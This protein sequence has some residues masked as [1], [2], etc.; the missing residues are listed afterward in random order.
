MDRDKLVQIA[1][2]TGKYDPE[3]TMFLVKRRRLGLTSLQ[4]TA[5]PLTGEETEEL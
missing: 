4:D 1:S 5:I 3:E 2:G